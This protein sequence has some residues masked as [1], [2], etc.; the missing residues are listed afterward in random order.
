M[1]AG[2]IIGGRPEVFRV[3][4]RSGKVKQSRSDHHL[5]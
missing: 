2:S 1:L 3:V 5:T 4:I